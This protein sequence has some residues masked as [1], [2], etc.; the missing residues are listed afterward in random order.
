M[1]PKAVVVDLDG[2][3]INLPLYAVLN[4][5]FLRKL[6]G[7]IYCR[8]P[9]SWQLMFVVKRAVLQEILKY[10]ATDVKVILLTARKDTLESRRAVQLLLTQLELKPDLIFLRPAGIHA[11]THKLK[12]IKR[13][14]SKYEITAIYEDEA[15]FRKIFA[16]FGPVKAPY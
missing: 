3:V 1:K 6:A 8:L 5:E 14:A 10:Q 4:A 2:T 11:R 13:I 12:A 16:E 9:A 15:R 7:G